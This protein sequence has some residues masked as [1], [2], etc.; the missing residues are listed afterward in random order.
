MTNIPML[1]NDDDCEVALPS[2]LDDRYIQQ[3]GYTR[4]NHDQP[5][6][7]GFLAL[8]QT[9]RLFSHLHKVLKIV[10]VA[11][12]N[13]KYIED[14]FHAT[15]A[16][17]VEPYQRNSDSPLE[18]AALLP[19]FAFQTG[20]FLLYRPNLSTLCRPVERSEALHRC[21]LVGQET[22]KYIS[23]SLHSA[24]D[25]ERWRSKA[26]QQ[27][28]FGIVTLHLWRC[29]LI[30]AFS[31][32][33]E[34]ALMCLHLAAAIGDSSQINVAC[35][36]NLAFF[37]DRLLDRIRSGVG[38][39]HHLEYDEEMLAYV[40]GDLQG[41]SDHA[42]VWSTSEH[43]V[44]SPLSPA[45]ATSSTFSQTH[46]QYH[47][48]QSTPRTSLD[49]DRDEP[50]TQNSAANAS[51]ALRPTPASPTQASAERPWDGWPGLER[52]LRQ[53]MEEHR[54][55]VAQPTHYYPPPHNPMKRVHLAP[56]AASP[57]RSSSVVHGQPRTEVKK[58]DAKDPSKSRN[59]ISIA[60]II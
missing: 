60:N 50:S 54:A 51:L 4:Q 53:L 10:P 33:Y 13:L 22:A 48:H 36:R 25:P 6:F 9:T 1:I 42:W 30:L 47:P 44:S 58:E 43:G 57:A 39:R 17:L 29:I 2:S 38:T 52:R 15:L 46:S 7:A 41:S 24:A 45:S 40:S 14:M 27:L 18:Q 32:D 21:T 37:L 34:A 56:E 8:I 3:R 59:R 16:L 20:R 11:P 12:Q 26:A 55:Q 5:P 49:R 23:R 28:S 31:A 19:L 35:G